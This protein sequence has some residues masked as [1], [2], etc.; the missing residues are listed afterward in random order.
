MDP[1]AVQDVQ[2]GHAA[3][4]TMARA[5]NDHA[6]HRLA[7]TVTPPVS[8][9][10]VPAALRHSRVTGESDTLVGG[11][12]MHRRETLATLRRPCR[13]VSA[14]PATGRC[15][16]T[17]GCLD[18]LRAIRAE[19]G[20]TLSAVAAATGISL[21]RRAPR[22]DGC[23]PC[24]TRFRPGRSEPHRLSQGWRQLRSAR[25]AR[26]ACRRCPRL[27]LTMHSAVQTIR[28]IAR[29]ETQQR[30]I[31]ALGLVKS[32]QDAPAGTSGQIFVHRR[33]ARNRD[34]PAE[35]PIATSVIGTVS[36]PRENDL[37]VVAVSRAAI[38]MRQSCW[39]VSDT[40]HV[41]P[42]EHRPGELVTILPGDET[43]SDRR[44]ELLHRLRRRHPQ[45]C[46]DA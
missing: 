19:R 34:R 44:I 6:R 39:D 11:A 24:D 42:P 46:A 25:L 17:P 45:G 9:L 8:Q 22:R 10:T 20:L 37:V 35:V 14:N 27:A 13:D 4:R 18:G 31:S 43:S 38:C 32:V 7:R 30:W 5:H 41:A 28:R 26:L 3:G 40:E 23:T 15:S 1:R 2:H 29:Y 36:L 21:C 16:T 12:A 33:T